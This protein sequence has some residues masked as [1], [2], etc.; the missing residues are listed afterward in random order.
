ME[1]YLKMKKEEVKK[2]LSEILRPS[3]FAN[4]DEDIRLKNCPQCPFKEECVQETYRKFE[5]AVIELIKQVSEQ[6]AKKAQ[7]DKHKMQIKKRV[8]KILSQVL[9]K[10]NEK[11]RKKDTS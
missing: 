4:P 2:I 10:E 6:I 3:C 1:N 9:V 8:E 7:E 5:E 11:K